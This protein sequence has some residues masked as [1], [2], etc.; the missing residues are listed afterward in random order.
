[1][2]VTAELMDKSYD[3]TMTHDWVNVNVLTDSDL[4]ETPVQL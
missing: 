3:L 1:L 4:L 2:P